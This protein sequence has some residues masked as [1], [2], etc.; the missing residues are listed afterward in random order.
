MVWYEHVG[1]AVDGASLGMNTPDMITPA[2]IRVPGPGIYGLVREDASLRLWKHR[3]ADGSR[4]SWPIWSRR[5]EKVWRRLVP[6]T[7]ADMTSVDYVLDILSEV[8][9]RP[10]RFGDEEAA[11]EELHAW[12]DARVWWTSPREG[13][14]D[15]R[16][17]YLPVMD[18]QALIDLATDLETRSDRG[19]KEVNHAVIGT[20]IRRVWDV[21]EEK[22]RV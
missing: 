19:V 11:R 15:R 3:S 5:S 10:V 7:G 4:T 22:E 18:R 6:D 20:W 13:T 12:V 14:R 16:A 9:F 8:S 21:I 2:R 17:L 1:H